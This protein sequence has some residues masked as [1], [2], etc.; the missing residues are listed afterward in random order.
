MLGWLA[1]AKVGVFGNSWNESTLLQFNFKTVLNAGSHV[2]SI[3][4]LLKFYESR[5]EYIGE[6]KL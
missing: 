3:F 4:S 2:S 5:C 6:L 1:L